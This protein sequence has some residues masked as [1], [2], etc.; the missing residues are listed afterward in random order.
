MKK[1][2]TKHYIC[3][4]A[5]CSRNVYVT[6]RRLI[7]GVVVK[8]MLKINFVKSQEVFLCDVYGYPGFEMYSTHIIYFWKFS[9]IPPRIFF[10]CHWMQHSIWLYH[11][12]S[13]V[14][15]FNTK[16][17]PKKVLNSD[18]NNS[19]HTHT[20]TQH[21]SNKSIQTKRLKIHFDCNCIPF[22]GKCSMQTNEIFFWLRADFKHSKTEYFC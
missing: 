8:E 2:K 12:P 20:H 10:T 15:A 3:K 11:S 18:N 9:V 4:Y 22:S 5:K 21:Q 17:G 7:G 6:Y 13:T 1:K 19:T 14:A 16:T